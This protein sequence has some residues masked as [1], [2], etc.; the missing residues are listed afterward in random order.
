MT[1]NL[2]KMGR[3]YYIHVNAQGTLVRLGRIWGERPLRTAW[4]RCW[5]ILQHEFKPLKYDEFISR[6]QGR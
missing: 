1:G 2:E 3:D 6:W 4:R 5:L